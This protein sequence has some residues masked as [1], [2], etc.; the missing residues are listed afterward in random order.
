MHNGSLSM[1]MSSTALNL[2]WMLMVWNKERDINSPSSSLYSTRPR[3]PVRL[4]HADTSKCIKRF[5]LHLPAVDHVHDVIYRDWRL[6]YVRRQNLQ[7][8]AV[9][10]SNIQQWHPSTLSL[11]CGWISWIPRFVSA[12]EMVNSHC[13]LLHFITFWKTKILVYFLAVFK[14]ELAAPLSQSP[15]WKERCGRRVDES[16]MLQIGTLPQFL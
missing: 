3:Y 13:A 11:P 1:S 16:V 15:G 9:S 5:L 4:E 14:G 2:N 7:H 10:C 6:G 8:G 12:W